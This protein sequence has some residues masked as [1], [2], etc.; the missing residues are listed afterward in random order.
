MIQKIRDNFVKEPSLDQK[1]EQYIKDFKEV[2]K[3]LF[4]EGNKC[5]ICLGKGQVGWNVE[6]NCFV[7][8]DCVNKA[9]EKLIAMR[10]AQMIMDGRIKKN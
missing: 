6:T 7:V 4:P 3:I 1:K 2:N 5:H 9:T 8:C 10:Q